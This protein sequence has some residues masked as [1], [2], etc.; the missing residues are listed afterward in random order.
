MAL[1]EYRCANCKQTYERRLTVEERDDII[2]TSCDCGGVGKRVIG[3]LPQIW[4]TTG[5]ATKLTYPPS[6]LKSNGDI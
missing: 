5:R 3:S 2:K 1:Y 4:L 6:E